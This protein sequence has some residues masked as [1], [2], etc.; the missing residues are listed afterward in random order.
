METVLNLRLES[1]IFAQNLRFK[2]LYNKNVIFTLYMIWRSI[3]PFH[4]QQIKIKIK[5]ITKCVQKYLIPLIK[6]ITLLF[7]IFPNILFIIN[8]EVGSASDGAQ[9]LEVCKD[10]VY[11]NHTY[12][13]QGSVDKKWSYQYI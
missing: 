9:R 3:F 10:K 4:E 5:I 7:S 13:Y 2:K 8:L 11:S 1:I 12:K 6:S